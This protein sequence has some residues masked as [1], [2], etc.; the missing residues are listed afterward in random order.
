MFFGVS[1]DTL[2]N[3]WESVMTS[4]GGWPRSG[5]SVSLAALNPAII[6]NNATNAPA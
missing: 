2:A 3:A 5:E 6:T 1:F 4:F